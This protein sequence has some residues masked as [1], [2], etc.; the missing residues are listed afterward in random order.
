MQLD[1]TIHYDEVHKYMNRGQKA[2]T[3]ATIRLSQRIHHGIVPEQ[4]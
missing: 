4:S 2:C 3:K 1:I